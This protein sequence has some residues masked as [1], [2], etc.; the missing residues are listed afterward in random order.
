MARSVY[1]RC[2]PFLFSLRFLFSEHPDH[3][4]AGFVEYFSVE[5]AEQGLHLET[6][7]GEELAHFSWGQPD[8]FHGQQCG[9]YDGPAFVGFVEGVHL[10]H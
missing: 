9:V 1:R 7:C 2:G 8:A 4:F 3:F 10:A 6:A 5:I